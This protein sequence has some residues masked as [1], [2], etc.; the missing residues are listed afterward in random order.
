MKTSTKAA[1][2]SALVFPGA[3]HF[4]LGRAMRGCLFLLPSALAALYMVNQ[5]IERA[6]AIAYDIVSGKLAP[7]PERILERVNAASAGDG[8]AMKA[9]VAV[10]LVC[11]AGSVIDTYLVGAKPK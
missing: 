7:D 8:P 5:I 2:T 1:L 9:A 4:L 11:W 6:Q 10:V 3:G